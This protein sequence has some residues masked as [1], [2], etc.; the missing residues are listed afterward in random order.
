MQQYYK[1]VFAKKVEYKGITFNSK[2][3][4]D[5]AMF[6]DGQLIDYKHRLYYHKPI[7]W[8]YESK[9]FELIPQETWVDRTE[10]DLTVKRIKRNKKHTLQRVVYTPDFYLPDYDL[11]IETKGFQFDDDLFRLRFRLFKHKYS[12]AKIWKITSHEDFAKIDEVL[13]NLTLED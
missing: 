11:Y 9:E 5:F 2:L 8:E 6:L 12:N 7:K 13:E 4:R 1:R 10:R 3:E